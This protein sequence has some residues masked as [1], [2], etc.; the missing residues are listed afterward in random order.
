MEARWSTHLINL[1]IWITPVEAKEI[2]N[3]FVNTR[4]DIETSDAGK[5]LY[6]AL[7]AIGR[8]TEPFSDKPLKRTTAPFIEKPHHLDDLETVS[9]PNLPERPRRTIPDDPDEE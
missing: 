1:E 8:L 3:D 5:K 2:L 7:M 9:L 6:A 4:S